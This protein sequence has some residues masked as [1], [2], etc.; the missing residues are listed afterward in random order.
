VHSSPDTRYSP[1]VTQPLRLAKPLRITEQSWPEGT[2]PLVSVFVWSFN[3]VKFIRESI[4]SILMQETT[5]PL[6]IVIH[7][8]ASTDG[9][10]DII[11]EYEAKHPQ[12]FHNILHTENQYSQGV[13]L[14]SPLATSTRG[15][16]LALSHGDDFWSDNSKLEIQISELINNRNAS[17]CVHSYHQVTT[18]EAGETTRS[19]AQHFSRSLIT[20]EDLLEGNP[21]ATSSVVLRRNSVVSRLPESLDALPMGDWPRWILASMK[22]PIL[23]VKKPMATYRLHGGGIWS[24]RKKSEQQFHHLILVSQFSDLL[25]DRLQ[26]RQAECLGIHTARLLLNNP[27]E[28]LVYQTIDKLR[29]IPP[30][31]LRCFGRGLIRAHLDA[32]SKTTTNL[33]ESQILN[34]VDIVKQNS[35]RIE[36]SLSSPPVCN[37]D[38]LKVKSVMLMRSGNFQVSTGNISL[39]RSFF[40]KAFLT[41]PFNVESFAR[42]IKSYFQKKSSAHAYVPSK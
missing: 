21:I 12:L 42:L 15:E 26:I 41:W 14:M 18:D 5:F 39:A 34:I 20:T 23:W 6:E 19:V 22:G 27:D 4:E 1:P 30:A 40:L 38:L 36:G 8:D 9:T 10:V 24:T 17:G 32:F 25:P 35:A 2:K 29:K 33:S 37:A 11:R 13:D 31:Q 3:D 7:D 28:K 16:Y